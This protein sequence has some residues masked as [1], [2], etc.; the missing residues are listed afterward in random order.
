MPPTRCAADPLCRRPAV[1]PTRCAADPLCR[2]PAVLLSRFIPFLGVYPDFSSQFILYTDA[3]NKAI[4]YVLGQRDE[5]GREHVIAYG[6]RALR[7]AELRYGITEKETLALV[8]G[9]RHFKI[10]LSHAKFLVYTDH[11]ATKFLQNVKGPTGRLGRRALFLQA[12][13]YDIIHKPGRVHNNAD[14]LSRMPHSVSSSD[15]PTYDP[16]SP[17]FKSPLAFQ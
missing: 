7:G 14:A 9:V 13:D 1:P 5:H 2:R 3:S 16:P 4:G 8:D 17:P 11:S 6:G 12:Y 10:Y 15:P